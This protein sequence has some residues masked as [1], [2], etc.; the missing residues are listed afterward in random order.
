MVFRTLLRRTHLRTA[1]SFEAPVH[2]ACCLSGGCR[3]DQSHSQIDMALSWAASF[4][5]DQQKTLILNSIRR[6]VV[7]T[8]GLRKPEIPKD[9]DDEQGWSHD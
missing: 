7:S 6:L 8:K 1:C 2:L 5:D 9:S 4:E 3:I